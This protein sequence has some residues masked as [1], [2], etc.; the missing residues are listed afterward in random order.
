MAFTPPATNI[1]PVPGTTA[2][3]ADVRGYER[4][5]SECQLPSRVSIIDTSF[6][7]TLAVKLPPAKIANDFHV[8]TTAL[9]RAD[10]AFELGLAIGVQL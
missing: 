4:S 8:I 9:S 6:V 1:I 2:P 5:G 3:H 10:L 7:Y